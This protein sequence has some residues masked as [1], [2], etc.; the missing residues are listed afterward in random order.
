MEV[1][2]RN[3]ERY[4]PQIAAVMIRKKEGIASDLVADKRWERRSLYACS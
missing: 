4:A 3:G 1:V 2:Q